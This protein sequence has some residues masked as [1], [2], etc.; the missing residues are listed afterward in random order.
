MD[1]TTIS[2]NLWD[3]A[4]LITGFAVVQ[5]GT[6]AYACA[7]PEF[8]NII[9]KIEIKILISVIMLLITAI[10]SYSAWWCS[11]KQIELIEKSSEKIHLEIIKIIRQAAY[12]RIIL[13]ILL[14]IPIFLALFAKQFAGIPLG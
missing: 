9:N 5:T 11:K 12:G 6:F 8:S 2:K 14:L 1:K 4:N 3:A 7:K 10:L 13:I